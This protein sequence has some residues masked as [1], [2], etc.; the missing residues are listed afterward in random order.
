[1]R[2]NDYLCN[3]CPKGTR[4]NSLFA[5]VMAAREDGWGESQIRADL[6]FKAA[7]DGLSQHEIDST[8]NSAMARPVS[9]RPPAP[10]YND[11]DEVIAWNAVIT[12]DGGV[13]PP[14]AE[15][16]KATAPS[17]PSTAPPPMPEPAP[18]DDDFPRFLR[19]LFQPTDIVSYNSD[20][21]VE[22]DGEI[23]PRGRGVFVRTCQDLI[24]AFTK[25]S[26]NVAVNPKDTSGVWVRLNPTDGKG[27]SDPNVV[28]YRHVLVESDE[29]PIEQQWELLQR[30]KV[31]CATIVHSG[32]KSLHAAVRI[33]AGRDRAEYDR[34]V[35]KL[36]QI[37][38]QHGMRVDQKNKNP[39]RLSRLPGVTRQGK[40]QYLVAVNV[41]CPSWNAWM[42]FLESDD[43]T[44]VPDE[45]EDLHRNPPPLSPEVIGGILRKGHKLLLAGPSKSGKSF[46][47][48]QLAA[49]VTTGGEWF[50]HRCAQGKVFYVNL[51][52]D[53]A[54]FW[55]RVEDVAMHVP[56]DY[57]RLTIWTLRGHVMQLD[58]LKARLF[59]H[60]LNKG[61]SVIIVDPIYKT[62]TGDENS[63]QEMTIFCNLI[64]EI[65]MHSGAAVVFASHFS[66]G[67]QGGKAAIDRTSGSGVFGRDPDA[68]GTLS[69]LEGDDQLGY[70]LDWT[71][72]EFPSPKPAT[73]AFEWPI[74]RYSSILSD[75]R[76]KGAPGSP[77]KV[78]ALSIKNALEF[79]CVNGPVPIK[80]LSSYLG[81]SEKTVRRKVMNLD[82]FVFK[83]GCV[84][85][86]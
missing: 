37:L 41:G 77:A 42:E 56:T 4:N 16:P 17:M 62:L 76:V 51:E 5:A 79:L 68:I 72:R 69:E 44:P 60:V 55:R 48:I 47:L 31:P 3:A 33:D 11:H 73:F 7:R 66:K 27:I 8:I 71:L 59:R 26:I 34:R 81:V 49:A 6:G 61:Y 14:P 64:E 1:M 39:S 65:A 35:A 52:I 23:K 29:L 22:D 18:A 20:Y 67:A 78:D 32:R 75:R 50:C 43:D 84:S 21:F 10:R 70:R 85:M 30:L 82:T 9:P 80:D 45:A 83:D 25:H 28:E 58:T 19:A 74:H 36:Y 53:R 40:P 38:E 57:S 86:K 15:Y 13:P 2:V 63:A 54:S 46:A 24:D 12:D